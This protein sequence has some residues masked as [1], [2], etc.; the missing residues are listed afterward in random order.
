MSRLPGSIDQRKKDAVL[1]AA[2]ALVVGRG[3][4]VSLGQIAKRSGV[5]KQTIY[6]YF[7]DKPGLF[8]ALLE[9]LAGS[10]ECPACAYPMTGA[11]A[12]F[13]SAYAK[14]VLEWLRG[15]RLATGLRAVISPE[16]PEPS[17]GIQ[18]PGDVAAGPAMPVLA[19][20]LAE[21]ARRGRLR[22]DDP[23]DAAGQFLDLVMAGRFCGGFPANLETGLA[24]DIQTAADACGRI[25]AQAYAARADGV[26]EVF[27]ANRT[28][29]AAGR[30]RIGHP[31]HPRKEAS[32]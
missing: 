6:N 8:H 21:A 32:R 28:V 1:E 20:V 14:T 30:A 25:F 9:S 13:F 12:S 2:A 11:P 15:L 10:A 17:H 27:I 29:L 5:S 7:G 18:G 31:I 3:P 16:R 4:A 24:A 19:R 23:E 22:V 26:G